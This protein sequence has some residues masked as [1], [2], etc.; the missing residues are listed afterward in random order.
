MQ[1]L[2]SAFKCTI[3]WNKYQSKTTI[4]N[5]PN[6][7]LDH[8]FDSS[9]H[10]VNRPFVLAFNAIDNRIGHSRYYLPSANVEGYNVIIHGKNFFDQPFKNYIK[11]YNNIQKITTDQGDDETTGCLVVYNYVKKHKMIATDISKQQAWDA[12][13]KAMQQI[14][15]QEI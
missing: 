14:K 5:A 6:Q 13:P 11:T 2:K 12:D 9:F 7:Y 4:Q 8:F 1:Q 3:N 10:G 15:L